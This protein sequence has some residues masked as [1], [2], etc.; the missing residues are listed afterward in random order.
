MKF[1][2]FDNMYRAFLDEVIYP[3][4]TPEDRARNEALL[5]G[6]DYTKYCEELTGYAGQDRQRVE[7]VRRS[8]A[9]RVRVGPVGNY[10]AGMALHPQ[11]F[12]LVAA[13]RPVYGP[14]GPYDVTFHIYVYRSDDMGM[15][16]TEINQ[17]DLLGKEP[18]M[19]CL[20]DGTVVLTAQHI[21]HN[22]QSPE[23]PV[24]RSVDGGVTWETNLLA[25]NRDYPRNLLLDRDGSIVFIRS[26]AFRYEF[27]TDK[28]FASPN[29]EICRSRDGG[30]TW[31][32]TEGKVDW[33]YAGIMEVS[34]AILD[35]GRMLASMR[36]QPSG[37][38]GEGFEDTVLTESVDGGLTWSTPRRVS[39]TGEVH[40]NLLKLRNGTVMASY[41]NYHVP[42]G[43]CAIISPDGGRT[44][45]HDR[46]VQLAHS[47]DYYTGWPVTVEMPDGSLITS[48]AITSHYEQKPASTSCE[49]VRWAME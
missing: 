49:V 35:D 14:N 47:H 40:F 3:G 16:W 36:R 10:K 34:T 13:C 42:Y 46:V 39:E 25:G 8:A 31:D 37:T 48:Y 27:E 20:P 12:L 43:V 21:E 18:S 9:R 7:F 19:V 17:T 11:G 44:W 33:D 15:S 1:N 6:Y 5:Q 45:D 2:D 28:P 29:L 38:K 4:K 32:R 26:L 41:T 30:R 24:Y 22:A 23:M